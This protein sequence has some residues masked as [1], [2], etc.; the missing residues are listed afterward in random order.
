MREAAW[1]LLLV[2]A[3]LPA[4]ALATPSP[5]VEACWHGE[6][7][8]DSPDGEHV[9]LD[10]SDDKLR[11]G[12]FSSGC[13]L[14]YVLTDGTDLYMTTAGHCGG[15]GK[16]W[17]VPGLGEIG[18]T[19]V[20]V[21]DPNLL[22]WR[23][24]ALVKIDEEDREHVEPTLRRFGGPITPV[25]GLDTRPPVSG[26]TVLQYGHGRGFGQDP[27]TKG[28]AGTVTAPLDGWFGYVGTVGPGD[29]GSPVRFATGEPAGIAV[30]VIGLSW[31][32][33]Q[34]TPS[35]VCANALASH[36]EACLPVEVACAELDGACN[37]PFRKGGIHGLVV[38]T[39]MDDAL[40]AFENWLA[41]D[42]EVVDGALPSTGIA[43]G[44]GQGLAVGA[45]G[46]AQ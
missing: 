7:H 27:A 37:A 42:L 6:I 45:P 32:Q 11:P 34:P 10:C 18:T 8:T 4:V 17:Y 20:S 43:T 44:S 14:G 38:S 13:T 46:L 5:S 25:D 16:R 2:T 26:E 15:E 23:D 29:S 24:Y 35:E 9:D 22:D 28:R 39:R 36:E 3:A 19:V 30:A 12:T 41:T 33:D 40:P 21:F 31:E 1:A